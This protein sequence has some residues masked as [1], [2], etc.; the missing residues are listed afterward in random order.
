MGN[1]ILETGESI[2]RYSETDFCSRPKPNW[3]LNFF[4]HNSPDKVVWNMCYTQN[5][6]IV[7]LVA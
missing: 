6:Y 7:A 3:F 1:R 2:T 5:V 4:V